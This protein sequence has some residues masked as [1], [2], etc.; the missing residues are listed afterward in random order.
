M[1]VHDAGESKLRYYICILYDPRSAVLYIPKGALCQVAK[2]KLSEL[3]EKRDAEIAA[4]WLELQNAGGKRV[5]PRSRVKRCGN[6]EIRVLEFPTLIWLSVTATAPE[7]QWA[8]ASAAA[9]AS[10][11]NSRSLPLPE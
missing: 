8:L 4:Q 5:S 9:N 2:S 6:H 3:L 1:K 7:T 11:T 10:P